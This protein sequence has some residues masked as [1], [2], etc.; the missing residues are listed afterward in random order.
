MTFTA[1]DLDSE[2]GRLLAKLQSFVGLI[3]EDYRLMSS[4]PSGAV[5]EWRLWLP[6]GCSVSVRF[7]SSGNAE[8]YSQSS[9]A[10]DLST[11]WARAVYWMCK[12][13]EAVVDDYDNPDITEMDK[14]SFED[15]RQ[16]IQRFSESIE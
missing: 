1:Q 3:G 7:S 6:D 13:I 16:A 5:A 2:F 15:L 12:A 9:Y 11:G 8:C 4:T 14:E 10:D